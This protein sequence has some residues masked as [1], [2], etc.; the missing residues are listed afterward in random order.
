MAGDKINYSV[1]KELTGEKNLQEWKTMLGLFL[2]LYD[3][4]KYITD[5]VPPTD[6]NRKERIKVLLSIRSRFLLRFTNVWVNGGSDPGQR[7]PKIIHQDILEDNPYRFEA[8]H[9]SS[10]TSR[11]AGSTPYHLKLAFI[12]TL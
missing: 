12:P 7:N 11:L 10:L 3:L 1:L 4:K 8:Q 9:R 6:D 2:S 5:D